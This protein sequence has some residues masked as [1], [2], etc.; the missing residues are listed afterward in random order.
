MSP[1]ILVVINA[2]CADY[3][4]LIRG[5]LLFARVA[6]FGASELYGDRAFAETVNEDI[7]WH[8]L[9]ASS[10]WPSSHI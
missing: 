8:G 6:R 2:P 9:I 1:S 10:G 4:I 7:H 3:G 5:M